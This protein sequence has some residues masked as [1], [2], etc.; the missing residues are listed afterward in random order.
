MKMKL[1]ENSPLRIK[2]EMK[3]PMKK[4]LIGL[5]ILFAVVFGY[6]AFKNVMMKRYIGKMIDPPITVSTQK[7]VYAQW[8]PKIVASGSVR[9]IEGVEVTT[10]IAGMVNGIYFTPGSRVEKGAMLIKLDDSTEVAQLHQYE[11]ARDLAKINLKRDQA[12]FKIS[13][14]SQATI[15]TDV[16]NLKEA[17]AQVDYQQS[18]V[19]KKS[20]RAPFAGRLGVRQVNLGQYLNPGDGV[21][22]LQRLDPIYVDFFL[23]QQELVETKVGQV[24]TLKCDAFPKTVFKG[25]IT[26]INPTVNDPTRNGLVEAT[27]ANPDYQLLPGMFGTV[28]VITGQPYEQ[29]TI[30]QAAVSYNAYGEIAYVIRD[31]GK[32][33]SGKPILKAQQTFVRVGKTRGDQ[34]AVLKGIEAGDEI[35]TSGQMKLKNN[36]KVT[37]NNSVQPY[38]NPNPK[39][40]NER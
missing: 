22:T 18:I 30:P 32:D 9:S 31:D 35:V 4:M 27:V 39:P 8:L 7:V 29:L 25:K 21:V 14:V 12:Q 33:K 20:I 17:Q 15:D 2:P 23:P 34:V 24:V 5:G 16:A 11:A 28:E 40:P 26:T 19:N 38:D 3:K 13:A 36:A 37:I 10:Q 1:D 6:Q